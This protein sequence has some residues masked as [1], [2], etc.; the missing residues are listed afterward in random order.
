MGIV[1]VTLA[2][3]PRD[4]V[5][6]GHCWLNVHTY[7]IWAFVGPVLF[8]LTVSRGPAG[9]GR[10]GDGEGLSPTDPR[11]PGQH[12]HPGPCGDGHRVQRPLPCPHVEPTALPSGADLDPDM[13]RPQNG[14]AKR[15]QEVQG[16]PAPGTR[17]TGREH[18][19]VCVQSVAV[20][21]CPSLC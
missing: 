20:W 8:V 5:A 9:E 15:K 4:Y 10:V 13:V 2:M 21:P 14:G 18:V 16:Q 3:L 1:A 19:R 11:S 7:A 12:L 17:L 6:P